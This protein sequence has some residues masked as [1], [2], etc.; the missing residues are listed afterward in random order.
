MVT[1]ALFVFLSCDDSEPAGTGPREAIVDGRVDV[2]GVYSHVVLVGQGCTGTLV[3]PIHVLT[4]AHCVCEPQETPTGGWIKDASYCQTLVNVSFESTP[5]RPEGRISGIVSAHPMFMLEANS[6]N[7]IT[8]GV[9]DLAV[10]TLSECAPD[11][12]RPVPLQ[13]SAS[14]LPSNGV[15]LGRIVGFGKTSC[16]AE[17]R[18]VDR[19]WGDAFVTAVNAELLEISSTVSLG[20]TELEGAVSWSGDS[21]GPLLMDQDSGQW[22]ISGV[23]TKATCGRAGGDTAWYTNMHTY[24][25]WYDTVVDQA[26]GEACN[27]PIEELEPPQV[28]NFTARLD[29]T[30]AELV[31]DAEITDRSSRGLT[32][33]DIRVALLEGTECAAVLQDAPLSASLTP[34]SGSTESWTLNHGVSAELAMGDSL[35]VELV[36]RDGADGETLPAVTRVTRCENDCSENGQCAW[37]EG[38]CQCDEQWSGESCDVCSPLCDGLSCGFDGCGGSCGSCDSPPP[39]TCN[40]NQTVGDTHDGFPIFGI[41]A[42]TGLNIYPDEGDCTEGE[43]NYTST[44]SACPDVLNYRDDTQ[45]DY[46]CVDGRCLDRCELLDHPAFDF[47]DVRP[48]PRVA[49]SGMDRAYVSGT[50]T[51][52][53]FFCPEDDQC[54]GEIV[55]TGPAGAGVDA[56]LEFTCDGE[57]NLQM[58]GQVWAQCPRGDPIYPDSLQVM[59]ICVARDMDAPDGVSQLPYLCPEDNMNYSPNSGYYELDCTPPFPVGPCSGVI[60]IYLRGLF[61]GREGPYIAKL[62]DLNTARQC[63]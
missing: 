15:S 21:G 39:A 23:L 61:A 48:G 53:P 40:I 55:R 3:T 11:T 2:E 26:L 57:I 1:I 20:G 4:A 31:V 47:A 12:V 17:S 45:V 18:A 41:G 35:C 10:I 28:T 14:R 44:V 51:M 59:L 27:Q 52:V 58:T 50:P 49:P 34:P 33:V 7:V 46:G 8:D 56:G 30:N 60:D 37:T 22:R 38:V 43:C 42:R 36:A 29:I 6:R 5:N 25:D 63:Q 16:D 24:R 13:E 19:W 54:T 62:N 9:A 32:S